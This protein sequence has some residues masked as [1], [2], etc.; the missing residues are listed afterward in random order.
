MKTRE[1]LVKAVEYAW[2]SWGWDYSNR[3][4]HA[5][6]WKDYREA[7]AALRAYELVSQEP[8]GAVFERVLYDNLW[9][10]YES[11]S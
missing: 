6:H 8:L 2:A 11:E 1:E 7:V 5:A 9:D 10:L 3:D 4:A